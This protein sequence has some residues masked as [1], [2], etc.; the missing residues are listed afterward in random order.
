MMFE[1]DHPDMPVQDWEEFRRWASPSIVEKVLD[2]SETNLPKWFVPLARGVAIASEELLRRAGYRPRA[3]R[4]RGWVDVNKYEFSFRVEMNKELVTRECSGL[5]TI[6]LFNDRRRYVHSDRVLAHH[7][8]A[9]PILVPNRR[10]A[11]SLAM[12]CHK[13]HVPGLRWIDACPVDFEG[14]IDRAEARGIE[15]AQAMASVQ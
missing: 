8:G 2:R 3:R 14:A 5:W 1:Q 4:P 13:N 15:E 11:M 12:H 9:T 7:V 6:E 10:S